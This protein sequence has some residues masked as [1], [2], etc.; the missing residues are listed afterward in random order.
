MALQQGPATPI[1]L[2]PVKN[3]TAAPCHMA[4]SQSGICSL[5]SRPGLNVYK[6]CSLSGAVSQSSALIYFSWSH[7]FQE[8]RRGTRL[9]RSKEENQQ[10]FLI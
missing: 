10:Q 3:L 8:E 9:A 5:A 7:R 6:C 1:Q 4:T 2:K